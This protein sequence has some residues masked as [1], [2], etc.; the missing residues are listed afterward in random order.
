MKKRLL[1]A[2]LVASAFGVGSA[3]FASGPIMITPTPMP[4][5]TVSASV[6]TVP[7]QVSLLKTYKSVRAFWL[8]RALVR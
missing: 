7:T 4:K 6:A 3:S 8:S 2:A 5:T 1:T